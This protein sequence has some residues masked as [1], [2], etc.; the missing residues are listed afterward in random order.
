MF[1]LAADT[2]A[3]IKCPENHFRKVFIVVFEEHRPLRIAAKKARHLLTG[4]A[5][6]TDKEH[7]MY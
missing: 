7:L 1:D 6:V 5:L 3:R 4:Q 2:I